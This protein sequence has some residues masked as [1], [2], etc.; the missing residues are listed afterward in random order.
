MISCPDI[1]HIRDAARKLHGIAVETPFLRWPE[2]LPQGG[3]MLVKAECLQRTGSF[4]FRG[5]YNRLCRLSDD[6]KRRGVVAYSSGNHAQGVAQAARLLNI[7]ATIVM[8]RDAPALKIANTRAY[9]AEIILYDRWSEDR[10]EIGRRLAEERGL[11]LVPPFDDPFIIAGQGTT[12]LEIVAQAKALGINL[13]AVL[14]PCS[15]GGLSA[16]IA[17]ALKAES[18][19]TSLWVIEPQGFDDTTRSLE[20]GAVQSNAPNAVSLCDAL[21]LPRPGRLTFPILQAHGGRGLAIS[22][23]LV[24][25]AMAQAFL[26]LK[27]VLEPGGAIALAAALTGHFA[28]QSIAIV[29]SGGNV[30]PALFA[31]A[32]NPR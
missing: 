18:P 17:L 12:G 32:L 20:T 15:G 22:D 31:Q 21:L 11:V 10:E 1:E 23:D 30:D 27:I 25:D 6:E 29:A 24:L 16:G 9:G 8:P 5:A 19:Q 26:K 13:D 28:G 2:A 14:V 7:P 3:T 4:K